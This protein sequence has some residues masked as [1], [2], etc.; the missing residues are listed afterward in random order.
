MYYIH[1]GQA[2]GALLYTIRITTTHDYLV[3]YITHGGCIL[4]EDLYYNTSDLLLSSK[5]PR[6]KGN[7]VM[8][9][10]IC[11]DR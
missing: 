1:N 2:V 3:I 6:G 7:S 8:L 9:H 4:K 11:N 5:N 10:Y